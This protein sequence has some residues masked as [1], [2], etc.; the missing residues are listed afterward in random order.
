MFKK[1]SKIGET[2]KLQANQL[3]SVQTVLSNA[4][5]QIQPRSGRI[6]YYGCLATKCEI[7]KILYKTID[8]K[9]F[10][11]DQEKFFYQPSDQ[12]L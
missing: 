5:Q 12:A 2:I 3:V 11:I 4:I 6:L 9:L 10:D 8:T 1:F 7:G